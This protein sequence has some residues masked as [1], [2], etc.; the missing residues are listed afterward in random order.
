MA[1]GWLDLAA[2]PSGWGVAMRCGTDRVG[3]DEVMVQGSVV[4][5]FGA[6]LDARRVVTG[7]WS[8]AVVRYL[9]WGGFAQTGKSQ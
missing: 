1:D 3:D 2:W 6:K 9:A 5:D 7:H 8:A 4:R